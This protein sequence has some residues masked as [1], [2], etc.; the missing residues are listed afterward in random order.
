MTL[1]WRDSFPI[2][3][4]LSSPKDA[5]SVMYPRAL[6]NETKSRKHKTPFDFTNLSYIYFRRGSSSS[7]ILIPLT[8]LPLSPHPSL[9]NCLYRH[10][11]R[12]PCHRAPQ[13]PTHGAP[14][15]PRAHHSHAGGSTLQACL[16]IAMWFG[17]SSA[18]LHSKATLAITKFHLNFDRSACQAAEP[19]QKINC[20]EPSH[21]AL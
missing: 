14:K 15:A 6:S 1:G 10:G 8:I 5:K 19:P 9:E 7:E 12:A 16:R 18:M 11:L 3:A 20:L 2:Y 13:L 4:K 21:T 17:R